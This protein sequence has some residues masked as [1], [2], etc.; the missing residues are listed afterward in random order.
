M[1]QYFEYISVVSVVIFIILLCALNCFSNKIKLYAYMFINWQN[2]CLALY[3]ATDIETAKFVHTLL[4]FPYF[5][6]LMLNI[7]TEQP[8]TANYKNLG[9]YL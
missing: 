4:L 8:L 2:V 9:A 1:H 5:S 6:V 7:F 3:N